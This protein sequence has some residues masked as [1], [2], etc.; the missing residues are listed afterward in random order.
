MSNKRIA[1]VFL[2]KY[3]NIKNI[4]SCLQTILQHLRCVLPFMNC[5]F[6]S[7]LLAFNLNGTPNTFYLLSACDTARNRYI[8]INR[9]QERMCSCIVCVYVYTLFPKYG[10]TLITEQRRERVTNRRDDDDDDDT[11]PRTPPY[12][13]VCSLQMVRSRAAIVQSPNRVLLLY[14]NVLL[15]CCAFH[16]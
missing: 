6:A 16:A 9:E 10:F 7:S 3:T 5:F 8:N 1:Y 2:I 12:L 13:Y 15:F 4:K 11:T 14:S